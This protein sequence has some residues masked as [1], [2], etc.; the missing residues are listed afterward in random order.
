MD[1]KEAEIRARE[2][3]EK[4]HDKIER[5]FFSNMYKEGEVWVLKGEIE[6]K[7]AR[8]FTRIR[9]IEIQVNMNTEKIT[10]YKEEEKRS[11]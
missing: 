10:R 9:A 5:I 3:L 2:Y 7:R 4:R 8:F 6:F 11:P 1:S